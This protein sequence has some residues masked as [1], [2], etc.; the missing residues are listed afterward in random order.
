MVAIPETYALAV[1]YHQEGRLAEAEDLYRQIIEQDPKHA[2]S[3]HFLGLLEYQRGRPDS[4]VK[5]IRYAISLNP[6]VAGYFLNLG[7]ACQALDQTEEAVKAYEEALR[8]QPTSA[9]A[10]SVLGN[11]LPRLDRLDDAVRHCQEALRIEPGFAG[12][13]HN[14]G[15]ALAKQGKV[16]DAVH[17]YQLSIQF[18][19]NCAAVHNN[20]GL[21]LA[22]Q[23]KLE[24]AI[25]QYQVALRLDPD[26]ATAHNNLKRAIA[27]GGRA[28]EENAILVRRVGSFRA[29]THGSADSAAPL[30]YADIPGWFFS[31]EVYDI[32]VRELPQGVFVEVGAWLGRSTAY[33]ASQ[34]RHRPIKLYVVDTWRGSGGRDA[35]S[36]KVHQRILE[37]NN[38]DVFEL[39]LANVA[40]C[41]LLH[42]V[43]PLRMLSSQAVQLF[44]EYSIDFCFLDAAHDYDSVNAD[45]VAWFPKVRHGGIIAG[46]DYHTDWPGVRKAVD[47]FFAP[48][49]KKIRVLDRSWLIHKP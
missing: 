26:N 43:V 19:P 28:D 14:L 12:A 18:D 23:G 48:L 2:D 30:T 10:H 22:K 5:S 27:D 9:E 49:G 16:E 41:G 42:Y 34:T 47:E 29:S 3:H 24:Q 44:P 4:A 11:L 15:N 40:K 37:S 13:H 17:Q 31:K 20:L 38:G 45:L 7:L 25:E 21:A 8:L 33:L 1:Q 6:S 32:A 35:K 46:D 36:D 39:F